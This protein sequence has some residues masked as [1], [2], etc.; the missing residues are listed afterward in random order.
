[1][2]HKF[3]AVRRA[4]SEARLPGT[5]HPKRKLRRR[6]RREGKGLTNLSGL[7]K[8]VRFPQTRVKWQGER[9]FRFFEN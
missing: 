1:M 8:I 3:G 5:F 7:S 2:L 9:Q 4:S 6:N